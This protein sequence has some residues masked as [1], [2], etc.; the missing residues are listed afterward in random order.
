MAIVP[1]APTYA[2]KLSLSKVETGS[3]IA[4]A[5][6]A[7]VVVALPIGVL[8]DRVGTRAL[9]VGSAALVALSTLGQGLAGDFWSLLVSRAAF[10]HALWTIWTAGLAWSSETGARDRGP[11]ALGVPV[12]VAGVG[13]TIGPAFAGLLAGWFGVRAPFLALAVA[14]ALVTLSFLRAGG[15]ESPYH[16]QPLAETLRVARHD[17]VVLA[18]VAVIVLV[19]T[20]GGGVNLLVPL[21]LRHNGLS[22]GAIGLV[23]SGSSA[24][25]ALACAGMT[26][27]GARAVTLR[28]VGIAALAY[29]A[30]T[31]IAVIGTSSAALI[32]FLLLRSPFWGAL[33]TLAYPLGALGAHRAGL[34]RATV[35]GLLN[36]LW[37]IAGSVAPVAA[38]AIAQASSERVAFAVLAACSL[39]A[40][41]WLL[42]ARE[43]TEPAVEPAR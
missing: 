9:T 23:L 10:G 37:G 21:E 16:R 29:A 20:M 13:I 19:G 4:A 14:A 11:A 26:R 6:I 40:G 41:L 12:A 42:A 31:S 22:S 28:V 2:E 17:R 1:V 24:V 30:A 25:F 18:G 5:G 15:E 32:V 36:L 3:V 38:G 8:A 7:T 43:A 33:S 39:A 27:L 35:M 34:G